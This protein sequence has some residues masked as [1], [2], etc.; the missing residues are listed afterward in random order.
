MA[1]PVFG[2]PG[3]ATGEPDNSCTD[4]HSSIRTDRLQVTPQAV[5]IDLGTQLDGNTLGQLNAFEVEPGA[6]VVL[7]VDI[8]NGSGKWAA[9][10]KHLEKGGQAQS[11]ANMLVW[12]QSGNTGWS[13]HGSSP[14]MATSVQE[15]TGAQTLIFSLT[16]DAATPPDTYDL[17]FAVA[18]KSS[19]M[20]YQEEHFYLNVLGAASNTWAGYD[21]DLDGNVNTG[22]W[23]SWIKVYDDHDF[24]W[25]YH[26]E[27]FVY[28]PEANVGESGGWAYIPK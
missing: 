20:F 22:T 28:M 5:L 14:Y 17:V 25:V 4:C 16:L 11:L 18:G 27:Q 6:T 15:N 21:K 10:L 7:S 23:L 2:F 1:S 13:E 12:S 24:V 26:M 3:S 9:Q 8:L 19:G